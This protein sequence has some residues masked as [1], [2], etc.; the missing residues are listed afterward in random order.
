MTMMTPTLVSEHVRGREVIGAVFAGCEGFL[1]LRA[2]PSRQRTHCQP[3]DIAAVEAFVA[4]HPQ[5]DVYFGVASRNGPAGGRL[6]DCRHL[7][8]LYCDLDCHDRSLEAAREALTAV[9]LAPSIT[10]GSGGGLHVYWLLREPIDVQADPAGLTALLRRVAQA[11]T[12]DLAAAE[13]ARIL[14]VPG[15][16]NHKY[17]PPRRVTIET[18]EPDRRYNPSDFEDWLPNVESVAATTAVSALD[19]EGDIPSGKRNAVLYRLARTLRAKSLPPAAIVGTLEAVN[20]TRCHPPLE[21]QE[22]ERL[23]QHALTQPDRDRHTPSAPTG[24]SA[25]GSEFPVLTALSDVTREAVEWVWRGRFARRKL[26]IVGGEPGEGKSTMLLD[27]AA[28]VTR[29]ARWPDGGEAPQG[30]VLLLSAE[31]GLGDTIA[32][33]LDAAG[34][35]DRL[36]HV[37]TAVRSGDGTTR[38]LDLGRDL[39][40][41]EAA[42]R[43]VRPVFVVVDPISAY[44]PKVD[45][46][47]DSDVRSVLAPLAVLADEHNCVIVGVMHLNKNASAKILHRLMGSVGFVAAARVVLAVAT[48][49]DDPERR[50]LL[51]V[52]NNLA[53]PAEV[54]A[55][56]RDG[57]RILW[58]PTPVRGVTADGVLGAATMDAQERQDAESFLRGILAGEPVLARVIIK[59]GRANGLSERTLTRVKARLGV[60]SQLVGF[61]K[62]GR[63]YWFLPASESAISG[64][65]EPA[66]AFSTQR[67]PEAATH[68]VAPSGSLCGSR[69]CQ[70][71]ANSDVATSANTSTKHTESAEG[72]KSEE[73]QDDDGRRY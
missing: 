56:R 17:D 5:E 47:R 8:A 26:C 60:K 13:P 11:A 43:Q 31:D 52:K 4:A 15:T 28:R 65:A 69:G 54:L 45:T 20:G 29:G 57:D 10:I 1:E 48:D 37:L 12:G 3:T 7:G 39:P 2:L 27:V 22:L 62:D 6:A 33:R 42:I 44:L 9:P 19:L 71:M 63:W 40:Q 67:S 49:P 64:S 38:G 34:A 30:A 21:R 18:F 72:A 66:E 61:G 73:R 70:E 16:P 68:T 32:P 36:V 24:P 58:E 59:N 41:L 14:R 46:W 55:F 25:E 23:I 51:P 50:L 35:D 53:L